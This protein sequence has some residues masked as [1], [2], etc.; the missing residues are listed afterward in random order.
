M[1][2]Q[3]LNLKCKAEL[4]DIILKYIFS[5]MTLYLRGTILSLELYCFH[6]KRKL[7]LKFDVSYTRMY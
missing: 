1:D 7:R 6:N 4:M 2:F 5:C 3:H